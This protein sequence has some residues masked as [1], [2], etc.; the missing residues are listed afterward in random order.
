MSRA[1]IREN[2]D[3]YHCVKY[4][5]NCMMADEHGKCVLDECNQYSEDATKNNS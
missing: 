4:K 2:D 3:W 1:F 5:E